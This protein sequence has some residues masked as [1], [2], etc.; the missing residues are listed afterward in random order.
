M[1]ANKEI[2][3]YIF[4]GILTTLINLLSYILLTKVLMLDYKSAVT[5]AWIVSVIFAFITNKLFVFMSR[6]RHFLSLI[7]ELGSFTLSRIA[8]FGLDIVTMI[9][10]IEMLM[11]ND[12]GVKIFANTLVIAFN[13]LASKYFVFRQVIKE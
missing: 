3:S 2:V 9:I 4:F 8:S 6:D 7:K 5:I 10:L 11:L 13:Y 12:L 1:T